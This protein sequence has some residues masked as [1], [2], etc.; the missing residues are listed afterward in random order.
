M[1]AKIY[2]HESARLF[3]IPIESIQEALAGGLGWLDSVFGR[4]ERLAR[5]S[6]EGQTLYYPAWPLRDGTDYVLVA[7]DDK[8]LGGTAFFTLDDP[9]DIVRDS[10]R[11]K[12]GCSLIVW[13]DMRRVSEERNM[14][15]AKAQVL[16]VLRAARLSGGSFRLTEIYERAANVFSGFSF[17]E[18]VNQFA[19]HPFF[20]LRFDGEI[21]LNEVCL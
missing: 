11:Y 7:P 8:D 15:Y 14:E 12:A 13:G 10:G 4:V 16:S 3:D 19:T 6:P 21:M 18:T 17:T 1:A 2:K 9:I 20:A 5:L